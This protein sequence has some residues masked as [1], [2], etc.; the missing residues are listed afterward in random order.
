MRLM[1]FLFICCSIPAF[2]MT[3]PIRVGVIMDQTTNRAA[4]IETVRGLQIGADYLKKSKGRAV[5]LNLEDSG[6]LATGTRQKMIAAV[7]KKFDI[8]IAEISSSKAEV[9]AQVAEE[10]KIVMITP[11][12]TAMSVT[13]GRKYVFRTCAVHSAQVEGL[14]KTLTHKLHFTKGAVVYDRGQLYSVDLAKHFKNEFEKGGGQLPMFDGIVSSADSFSDTFARIDAAAPEFLFLPMYEDV[15]ARFLSQLVA[16]GPLKTMLLGGDAWQPGEVFQS[17]VF[18]KNADLQLALVT[19]HNPKSRMPL[20]G[21]FEQMYRKRFGVPPHTSGSYLAFDTMLVIGAVFS[22]P[23][24]SQSEIRD[25]LANVVKVDGVTGPIAF[26]GTQDPVKKL[27]YLNYYK[28]AKLL[29]VEELR[30]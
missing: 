26:A 30:P 15:T 23:K 24:L 18:T 10:N 27:L 21:V 14:A 29:K 7:A 20:Q 25:R 9:A 12:A 1:R 16:R 6:P 19:H 2:A 22:G 13:A 8:V 17:L 11:Y 28:G 5:D 3:S 4:S